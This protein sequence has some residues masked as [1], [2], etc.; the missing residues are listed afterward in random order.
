MKLVYASNG[1]QPFSNFTRDSGRS[2]MWPLCLRG[3]VASGRFTS[4]STMGRSIGLEHDTP[5]IIRFSPTNNTYEFRFRTP[6]GDRT[7]LGY[8]TW[9]L[10]ESWRE[11]QSAGQNTRQS[12]LGL[13]NGIWG[14]EVNCMC[15]AHDKNQGSFTSELG[16]ATFELGV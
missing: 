10:S 3:H 14:D 5:Y 15:L 7:S 11:S 13:G 9:S 2:D 12:M 1:E 8:Y 16:V 4:L 6:Q